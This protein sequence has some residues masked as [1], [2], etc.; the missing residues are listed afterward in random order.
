MKLTKVIKY[1][2]QQGLKYEFEASNDEVRIF[3][4]DNMMVV[5]PRGAK[6]MVE[7]YTDIFGDD[8]EIMDLGA[9]TQKQIIEAIE[10]AKR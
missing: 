4:D 6:Y 5:Y 1:A 7:V 2:E 3:L 8:G 9:M 10:Q